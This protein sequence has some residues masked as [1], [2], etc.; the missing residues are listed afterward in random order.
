MSEKTKG[1]IGLIALSLI[2]GTVGIFVRLL[3]PNFTILQQSY[4]R[5]GAAALLSVLVF[6]SKIDFANI[7]SISK[8]DLGIS[9]LRAALF[10]TGVTLFTLAIVSTNF[11]NV[12]LVAAVPLL[13]VWGYLL[14]GQKVTVQ[15]VMYVLI[16]FIGVTLI[17]VPDFSHLLHWGRGE[18]LAFLSAVFF[19]ISYLT[20]NWQ[21]SKLS[22]EESTVFILWI[23][24]VLLF[25][26]AIVWGEPLPTTA[27]F[28][29]FMIIAILGAGLFN[30]A[31]IFLIN[32]GFSRVSA[33]LA[34]NILTLESVFA[35]FVGILLYS[36]IPTLQIVLGGAIVLFSVYKMNQI[37]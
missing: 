19:D 33:A 29:P 12:S 2:F 36:E 31:N 10:Y 5:I 3:E 34:G 7:F 13:P 32:Y 6:S 25:L 1:V 23:G 28:S 35:V 24:A 30:V 14:L 18:V 26:A 27:A 11:G 15:Q 20:R 22:N 4:L 21:S 9:F 16:G 17:A 37:S 8:K